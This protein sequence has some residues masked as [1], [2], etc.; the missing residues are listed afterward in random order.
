MTDT[1]G[2]DPYDTT[3]APIEPTATTPPAVP[4]ARPGT[5]LAT[6]D[7]GQLE[8][9]LAPHTVDMMTWLRGILT[10]DEFPDQDADAVVIGMLAAIIQATSSEDALMALQLDRAKEMCGNEPGG[11]SPVMDITGARPMKSTVEGGAGCYAIFDAIRLE[12]GVKIRFTTGSKAV[13]T[14]VWKHVAEGWMPLRCR[15]E[16]RR[17]RTQ[18][19][20]YPLNLVAGI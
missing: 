8:A 6:I 11:K 2:T 13:Q 19:G 14:V 4:A 5:M 16:I 9:L 3:E 7:A 15:L 20:F 10:P 17:E 12:D 1:R 18:A